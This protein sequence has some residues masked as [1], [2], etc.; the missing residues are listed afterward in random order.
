MSAPGNI[1]GETKAHGGASAFM[2]NLTAVFGLLVIGYPL[3]PTTIR[4]TLVAWILIV[5]TFAQFIVGRFFQTTK[6]AVPV[7]TGSAPSLDR[8]QFR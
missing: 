3:A 4:T 2:G 8:E 5:V 1:T 6:S 7:R